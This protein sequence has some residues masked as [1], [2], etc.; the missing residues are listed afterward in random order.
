MVSC[1]ENRVA[2]L[3]AAGKEGK[4]AVDVKVSLK[5]MNCST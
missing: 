4:R 1:E 3:S 5:P 2:D